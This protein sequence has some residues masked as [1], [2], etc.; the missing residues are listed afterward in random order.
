M[1]P[2]GRITPADPPPAPRAAD[3]PER[4]VVA[5]EHHA[6]I[7]NHPTPTA[8]WRGTSGGYFADWKVDE[9]LASGA[10]VLR[11]GTGREG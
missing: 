3:L 5:S 9:E 10:R 7:K 1:A 8:P 6:Y 11:V 2:Y 4:S